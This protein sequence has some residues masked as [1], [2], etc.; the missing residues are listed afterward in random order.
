M[1]RSATW[2]VVLLATIT[3]G[4][5]L[6]TAKEVPF[7]FKAPDGFVLR[8]KAAWPDSV[9]PEAVTRVVV[10]IHGSGPQNMDS[11]LT[12]VSKDKSKKN[13]FFKDVSDALVKKGFAVVRYNKRAFEWRMKL[14]ANKALWYTPEFQK[15]RKTAL[16]DYVDDAKNVGLEAL[17]RFPKAKLYLLGVSQGT[18]IGLQVMHQLP[19]VS[20]VALIGF[21]TT[22]LM[23]VSFEQIVYRPL[24]W[25][26]RVDT[27][28]DGKLSKVEM[29]AAGKHGL[30]LMMQTSALDVD[31]DGQ[32]SW[33][34]MMGGNT[35]NLVRYGV[36][37]IDPSYSI[38]EERYPTVAAILKKSK[39]PVLFFQGMYDNQTPFYH[40]QAIRLCAQHLWKKTNLFFHFFPKL[41]HILDPRERYDDIVY[42][43]VDPAALTK[44]ANEMDARFK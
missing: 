9:A 11:D 2:L 24:V 20:G 8:A 17:R 31:G 30:A 5:P 41:G 1:K 21:Y 34:E 28:H 13:L 33:M 39:R 19:K 25:F 26:R 3:L 29:I 32:I 44:V 35:V 38:Q 36:N 43:H 16:K 40:A 23:T 10:L 27:N 42:R 12:S 18:Y 15:A 14:L 4:I 22:S 37:L 6:G 7:D